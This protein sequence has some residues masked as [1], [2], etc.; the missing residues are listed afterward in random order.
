MEGEKEIERERDERGRGGGVHG[1]VVNVW[2]VL[3]VD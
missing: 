1:Y 3:I 2:C